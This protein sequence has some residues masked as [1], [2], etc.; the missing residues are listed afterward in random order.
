M[1]L[2]YIFKQ[3]HLSY[4]IFSLSKHFG[5]MLKLLDV[6]FYFLKLLKKNVLIF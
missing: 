5:F 6:L 1:C 2:L 3:F 4:E